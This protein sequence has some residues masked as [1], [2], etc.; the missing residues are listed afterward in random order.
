MEHGIERRFLVKILPNLHGNVPVLYEKYFLQGGDVI[1]E[2]VQKRNDTLEYEKRICLSRHESNIERSLL[3][4]QEFDTLKKSASPPLKF[5][6]YVYAFDPLV[7]INIFKENHEGFV[8]ADVKFDTLEEAF[9]FEIPKWMGK[10]I[11]QS[12]LGIDKNLAHLTSEECKKLIH[13]VIITSR[14]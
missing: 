13:Q 14:T 10:E 8:R 11:T 2:A 6:K 3:G 4:M 5:K 7:S 12:P 1:E 9:D